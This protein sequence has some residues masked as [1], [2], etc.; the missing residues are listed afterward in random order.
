MTTLSTRF[1]GALADSLLTR[2]GFLTPITPPFPSLPSAPLP[3]A[4][5][6]STPLLSPL[7]MPSLYGHGADHGA[8]HETGHGPGH[9]AGGDRGDCDGGATFLHGRMLGHGGSFG[10][11]WN[12][13][14]F[15]G[16]T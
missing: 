12:D 4:P 2:W 14:R 11:V 1:S 15:L 6:L 13:S 7:Q 5:L 9:E 16:R 8:G 10:L 3:A